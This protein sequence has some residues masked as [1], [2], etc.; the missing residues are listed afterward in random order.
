MTSARAAATLQSDPLDFILGKPFL[1]TVVELGRARVL[2]GLAP[3][4]IA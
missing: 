3:A 1:R 2:S 4:S